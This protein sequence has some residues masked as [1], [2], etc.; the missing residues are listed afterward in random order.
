MD[1]DA[2]LIPLAA[3]QVGLL[4]SRLRCAAHQ[5]A[6]A[7]TMGRPL[8]YCPRLWM[9]ITRLRHLLARHA[10]TRAF[11]LWRHVHVC[12]ERLFKVEI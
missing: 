7:R 3:A 1:R 12:L 6:Y 11:A 2:S 5:H 8:R 9:A 10:S 4:S